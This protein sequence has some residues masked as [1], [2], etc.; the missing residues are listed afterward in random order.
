MLEES[1][2][3]VARRHPTDQARDWAILM[4][5]GNVAGA[6]PSCVWQVSAGHG[7]EA[8][9]HTPRSTFSRS[10]VLGCDTQ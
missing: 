6:D 7:G 9:S 3:L 8:V 10:L 5:F 2:S 1:E 4:D